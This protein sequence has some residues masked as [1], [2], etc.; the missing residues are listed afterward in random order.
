MPTY[1]AYG[2]FLK[3][4]LSLPCPISRKPRQ[5]VEIVEESASFFSRVHRELLSRPNESSWFRHAQL[6]DGSDYLRWSGLFEFLVTADGSRIA[7]RPLDGATLEAFQTYLLAQVLSFALLKQGVESLHATVVA[8]QG[9]ALVFLGDCGAGKST[10]GAAFLQSGHLLVTD[11]LLVLREKD[12]G[13][14]AHSGLPRIKLFPEIAQTLLG[15]Q[16]EGVPMNDLTPKI[17]IPLDRQQCCRSEARLRAIY[18]F[19][20]RD[21]SSRTISIRPLSKRAATVELLKNTFN[22]LVLEKER[23]KRQFLFAARLAASV[24]VSSLTYPRTLA[25]LPEVREAILYDVSL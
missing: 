22:P 25:R 17:I 16:I 21:S 1:R 23:I 18:V 24:R 10:L 14:W 7:C 6:P 13:F 9:A 3:S 2:Q 5:P 20:S 11:D 12:D 4:G 8:V 15:R 19:K